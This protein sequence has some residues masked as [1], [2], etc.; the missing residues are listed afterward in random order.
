MPRRGRKPGPKKGSKRSGSR[1]H[2]R[3]PRKTHGKHAKRTSRV[4]KAVRGR[5]NPWIKSVVA[6]KNSHGGTLKAAM[7]AMSK[8]KRKD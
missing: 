3:K 5:S 4:K 2:S 7:K 6:Y 1:S 8:K